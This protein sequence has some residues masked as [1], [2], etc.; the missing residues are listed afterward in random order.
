MDKNHLFGL[1]VF[2]ISLTVYLFTLAPG[3]MMI[4]AGELSAVQY[5]LGIAHATG[6]PLFTLI[7]YVF[8]HLPIGETVI[9]RSNLLSAIFTSASATGLFYLTHLWISQSAGFKLSAK[10]KSKSFLNDSLYLN[11]SAFTAAIVFA[12]H[13]VVWFQGTSVEVYSLHLLLLVSALWF[14]SQAW[15]NPNSD[16]HWLSAGFFL[17]L[18]F[19]NHLSS[20]HLL[21]AFVWIFFSQ[22]PIFKKETW[23]LILKLKLIALLVLIAFYGFLLFRANQH[24]TLSWGYVVDF[25]R[26]KWHITGRQYSEWV[27]SGSKTFKKQ[28]V[29][30]GSGLLPYYAYLGFFIS[31]I[32][33]YGL[34]VKNKSLFNTTLLWAL[35][36]IGF[37]ANYD[38]PDIESYFLLAYLIMS[39][40]V[41]FGLIWLQEKAGKLPIVI[42]SAI[43]LPLS[44]GAINF[45]KNNQ[46]EVFVYDDYTQALLNQAE[47]NAL[48]FTKQWDYFIASSYYYQLVNKLR[49]DVAVIDKE[50]LRRS[51]YLNMIQ[52]SKPEVLAVANNEIGVFKQLLVPFENGK[53]N[54]NPQLLQETWLNLNTQILYGNMAK[55]PV[56]LTI[57]LT[58][59]IGDGELILP[60]GTKL[61]PMCLYFKLLPQ[62]APYQPCDCKDLNI[63]F[64]GPQNYYVNTMRKITFQQLLYRAEYELQEGF[65]D[66]AKQV[67]QIAAKHKLEGQPMPDQA[68]KLGV[69]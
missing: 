40:W 13:S 32:G 12:L 54:Y 38:I 66:K 25:S 44:V 53:K 10:S 16:N 46:K 31:M 1:A 29:V 64:S 21:P 61:I 49:P 47:P 11:L 45:E 52:D 7:G 69:K 35:F 65:S 15:L 20:L 50:L 14:T 43:L 33:L 18:C 34:W 41:G 26:L 62:N 2:L 56:Y 59:E 51:W 28:I 55:R 6:Y 22:K 63:R 67:Y 8:T 3:L 57:E 17:S 58:N 36:C 24:P 9:F 19:T 30:F 4:D 48:I 39:T 42:A 37:S 27:F 5:T 60:E 68:Q 23:K